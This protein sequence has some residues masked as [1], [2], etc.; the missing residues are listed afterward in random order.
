MTLP[1][2]ESGSESDYDVSTDHRNLTGG[3]TELVSWLSGKQYEDFDYKESLIYIHLM[4]E[5]ENDE[6]VAKSYALRLIIHYIGDLVQ[7]FHCEIRY[8]SEFTSGDKGANLFPLKY[9]YEVDELHALWDK[10]LYDGYHNIVR[11]FTEDTWDSF[12]VDVD[13]VMQTYAYAVS[14]PSVYET[15]DFDAIS[16]ESHE[17]AE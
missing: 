16:H 8:N 15:V 1:W 17:I 11:P 10:I 9:H 12:Q 4:D 13:N 6:N 14:D 3:L 2:I 7:P 5:F